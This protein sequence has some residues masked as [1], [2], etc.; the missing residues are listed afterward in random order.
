MSQTL[1]MLLP[2]RNINS[3]SD[4]ICF[5]CPLSLRKRQENKSSHTEWQTWVPVGCQFHTGSHDSVFFSCRTV[6]QLSHP[7]TPWQILSLSLMKCINVWLVLFL[8]WL[9]LCYVVMLTELSIK[10]CCI[11]RWETNGIQCVRNVLNFL[12][13]FDSIFNDLHLKIFWLD[14]AI[15]QKLTVNLILHLQ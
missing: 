1:I 6:Q 9:Q 10:C 14:R 15:S 7:P 4:K 3:K 12:I 5:S 2:T 11:V 13:S 8:C